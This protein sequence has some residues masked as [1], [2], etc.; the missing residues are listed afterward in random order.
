MGL[1]G[2]RCMDT[3]AFRNTLL[4][5][6]PFHGTSNFPD[7][8]FKVSSSDGRSLATVTDLSMVGA[9]NFTLFSIFILQASLL[10]NRSGKWA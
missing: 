9:G 4:D 7:M 1:K 3:F 10:D 5:D 2:N 8:K 6:T